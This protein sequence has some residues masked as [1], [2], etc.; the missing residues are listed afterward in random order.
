MC[1]PRI[2][3]PYKDLASHCL[4]RMH[5]QPTQSKTVFQAQETLLNN[6]LVSVYPDGF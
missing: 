1:E 4:L 2:S 5:T 3:E 6:I